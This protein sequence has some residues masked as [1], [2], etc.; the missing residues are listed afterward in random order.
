MNKKEKKLLNDFYDYWLCELQ[1]WEYIKL[2]STWEYVKLDE[3]INK[4][5]KLLELLGVIKGKKND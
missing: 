5:E 2:N 4:T 1:V 3:V